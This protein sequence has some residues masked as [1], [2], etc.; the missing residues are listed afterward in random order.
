MDMKEAGYV[1]VISLSVI[2]AVGGVFTVSR[3]L[4]GACGGEESGSGTAADDA[5]G[6]PGGGHAE[7]LPGGIAGGRPEQAAADAGLRAEAAALVPRLGDRDFA[8]RSLALRKLVEIGAP[9]IPA[10]E[11]ALHDPD[12]EIRWRA[13]EALGRIRLQGR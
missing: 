13:F 4:A 12:P 7:P 8:A 3:A 2:A 1:A 6:G 11:K 9:A 5:F 10:L